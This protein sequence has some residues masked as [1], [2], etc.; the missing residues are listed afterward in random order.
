MY[1]VFTKLGDGEWMHVATREKLEQAV[2][3]AVSLNASWPREYVVRDS[4]GNG[5]TFGHERS[6]HPDHRSVARIT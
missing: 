3:L 2:Q 5:V 1:R 6:T 4:Q